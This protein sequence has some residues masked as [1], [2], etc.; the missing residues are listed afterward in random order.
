M[1]NRIVIMELKK[2]YGAN[3][4]GEIASFSRETAEHIKK[5]DG[6]KELGEIDAGGTWPPPQ[7]AAK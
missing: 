1:S 7:K 5:H 2:H 3:V 4:A 6:G